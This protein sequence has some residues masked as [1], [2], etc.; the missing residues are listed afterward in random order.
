MKVLVIGCGTMGRGIA[1]L[2][3]KH[4]YFVQ[5]YDE[6]KQAIEKTLNYLK[7]YQNSL[8]QNYLEK[9]KILTNLSDIDKETEIVIEAIV[10]DFDKK[11]FLF[12]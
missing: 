1:Y 4:N 12:M 9:L 2:F 5:I 6:N 8:P 10:E 7:E 3:L 11:S